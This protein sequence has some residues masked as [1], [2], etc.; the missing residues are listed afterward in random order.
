MYTRQ[1]LVTRVN[2]L[3]YEGLYSW[4]DM[5]WE[6]DKAIAELNTTLVSLYPDFTSVMGFETSKYSRTIIPV[7]ELPETAD[8]K[9]VY[10]MNSNQKLYNYRLVKAIFGG[11]DN[12]NP[13]GETRTAK[14]ARQAE[15]MMWV[16]VNEDFLN[17]LPSKVYHQFIIPYVVAQMLAREDEFGTLY[18][19]NVTQYSDGLMNAFRDLLSSVPNEYVDT[20][21]GSIKLPTAIG[22]W[23]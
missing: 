19:N 2:S 16:E 3:M 8:P 12:Y 5:K 10:K 1:Q 14:L 15:A 21:G 23:F 4:E 17:L 9:L 7:D 6:F 20:Q 22:G 13:F 11:A 18:Q